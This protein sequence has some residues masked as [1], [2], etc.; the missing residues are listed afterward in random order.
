MPGRQPGPRRRDPGTPSGRRTRAGRPTGGRRRARPNVPGRA[1]CASRA[2]ADRRKW[3]PQVGQTRSALSSC[4]LKSISRR[5]GTWS[6]GRAGRRRG[7]ARNDGSLI[8]IRRASSGRGADGTDHRARRAGRA[9]TPRGG[10]GQARAPRTSARRRSAAGGRPHPAR[11][12]R[13]RRG[14][15]AIGSAHRERARPLAAGAP[16]RIVRATWRG[17][18]ASASSNRNE[19]WK[20]GRSRARRSAAARVVGRRWSGAA[21][22]RRGRGRRAAPR[23]SGR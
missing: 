21:Y 4:L 13:R 23:D 10:A 7:A 22:R 3:W 16:D 15:R 14:A 6:T 1:A 18:A 2:A 5:S 17:R 9:A 11:P 20:R 19:G 8:G 12:G